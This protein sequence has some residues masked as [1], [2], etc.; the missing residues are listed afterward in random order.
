MPGMLTIDADEVRA[1][2]NALGRIETELK[3]DGEQMTWQLSTLEAA[4]QY[5]EVGVS[6]HLRQA[7]TQLSEVAQLLQTAQTRLL[8]VVTDTLQ[9]EAVIDSG[10][11]KGATGNGSTSEGGGE[12][13]DKGVTIGGVAPTN[14]I[15]SEFEDGKSKNL[16]GAGVE[17]S[18]LEVPISE[19]NDGSFHNEAAAKFGTAAI[20]VGLMEKNGDLDA[21]IWGEATAASVEDRGRWGSTNLG[22]TYGGDAKVLS[23]SGFAGMKDDSAGAEIGVNLAEVDG[24][25]GTDIAGVNVGV[26]AGVGLKLE[27]G[28]EVGKHT[29][30]KLGPFTLGL[31]FGG[32][33]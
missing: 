2:A 11:V 18:A 20:G 33:W 9:L 32:A 17:G 23:A 27:L 3:N 21:G 7:I 16:F 4:L 8:Q 29:Q 1:V 25:L 12:G 19:T 30:I 10:G 31:D 24:H 5:A 13:G 15:G 22:L 6:T 28:V 14:K 26:N